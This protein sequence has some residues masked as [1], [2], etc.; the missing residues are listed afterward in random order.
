MFSTC[1]KTLLKKGY[2]PRNCTNIWSFADPKDE[3]NIV[4]LRHNPS[5]DTYTFCYGLKDSDMS[6]RSEYEYKDADKLERY[7]KYIVNDY[8]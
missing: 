6:Y 5:T 7:I 3:Y 2:I 4:Y 8:L 1:E